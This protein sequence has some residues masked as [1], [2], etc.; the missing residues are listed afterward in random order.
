M[1]ALS[2]D[3]SNNKRRDGGWISEQ[4]KDQS[5]DLGAIEGNDGWCKRLM[6]QGAL[7]GATDGACDGVLSNRRRDELG[8]SDGSVSK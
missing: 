7:D 6:D 2:S 4:L 8:G 3:G 1:Q 5:M